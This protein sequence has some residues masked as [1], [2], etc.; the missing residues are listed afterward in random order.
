MYLPSVPSLL[1]REPL[2]STV[3]C[4]SG[5]PWFHLS[6]RMGFQATCSALRRHITETLSFSLASGSGT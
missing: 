1:P 4:E 3:A 5:G 2:T 6:K